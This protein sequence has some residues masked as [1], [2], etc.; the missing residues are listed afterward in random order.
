M[1]HAHSE[2]W[3]SISILIGAVIAV[4]ALVR[5]KWEIPLLLAVF[6]LWGLW[7]VRLL[8]PAWRLNRGYRRRVLLRR[9][10]R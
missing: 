8:I 6:A 10:E 7:V 4:L 3:S 5:G 1:K 2:L 9:K